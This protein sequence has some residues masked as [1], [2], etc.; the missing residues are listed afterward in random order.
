MKGTMEGCEFSPAGSAL[1]VA[2]R[3]FFS[4][5]QGFVLVWVLGSGFRVYV[6]GK[7]VIGK[8]FWLLLVLVFRA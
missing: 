4:F 7:T 5:F 8:D 1:G 6:L 3:R 2:S